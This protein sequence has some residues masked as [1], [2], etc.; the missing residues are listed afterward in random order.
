MC[1]VWITSLHDLVA[2][3][4]FATCHL[5]MVSASLILFLFFSIHKKFASPPH[6]D[7]FITIY[8]SVFFLLFFGQHTSSVFNLQ[9]MTSSATSKHQSGI[10]IQG[11]C[12]WLP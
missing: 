5:V 11:R 12:H 7:S 1:V 3:V 2:M 4:C 10:Y 6:L 8:C 9:V